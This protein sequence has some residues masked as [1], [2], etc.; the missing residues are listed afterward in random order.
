[1]DKDKNEQKTSDIALA[2]YL[3]TKIPLLNLE[4]LG[5]RALFIFPKSA[6]IEKL[7][8]SYRERTAKVEPLEYFNS[9]KNLKGHLY[10]N[11]LN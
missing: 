10:N 6:Q 9:L 1:M 7:E 5:K 3:N 4:W 11:D 8:R 2:A